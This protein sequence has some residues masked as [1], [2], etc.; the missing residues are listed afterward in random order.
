MVTD[1]ARPS[2][3]LNINIKSVVRLIVARAGRLGAGLIG[4]LVMI[5]GG[6]QSWYAAPDNFPFHT[7]VLGI[8]PDPGGPLPYSWGVLA[9]SGCFPARRAAGR[10]IP[11]VGL[12]RHGSE[13]L[14]LAPEWVTAGISG[15]GGTRPRQ[16]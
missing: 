7:A 15:P 2:R 14:T 5:R 11:A 8:W 6:S 16:C 13:C 10:A 9:F 1:H 12:A 3:G 4:S